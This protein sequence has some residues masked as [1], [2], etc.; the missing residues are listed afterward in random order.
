MKIYLTEKSEQ[1]LGNVIA[2]IQK[3][4][5]TC[6]EQEGVEA[7][8]AFMVAFSDTVGRY[9]MDWLI[10]HRDNIKNLM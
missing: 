3:Q 6:T 7:A 4:K 8:L 10:D 5:H 2:A 9:P 1:L